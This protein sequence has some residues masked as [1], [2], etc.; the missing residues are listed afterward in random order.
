MPGIIVQPEKG[1]SERAEDILRELHE[2]LKKHGCV[3]AHQPNGMVLGKVPPGIGTTVRVIAV[4]RI[5]TPEFF[6]WANIDWTQ[7]GAMRPGDF[8][9]Q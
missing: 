3:L 7:D 6:E 8:R 5:I 1:D 9:V 2:V 4:V